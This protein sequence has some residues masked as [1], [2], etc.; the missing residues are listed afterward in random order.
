MLNTSRCNPDAPN[1][2][3][4]CDAQGNWGTSEPCATDTFCV[5]GDCKPCLPET[6]R[7]S[8]SG[9][10]LCSEAGEWVNQ[11]ACTGATPAC[12]EGT[13]VSCTPDDKRCGDNVVEVCLPDGSGWDVFET[14]SGDTPACL[15]STKTCGRC[16]LDE[17]QC[18]DDDV[19]TCDSEGVFQTTEMCS[20]ST[21]QCFDDECTE[22]DPDA[23]ERRCATAN[24]TQACN[25]DGSW[26]AA[27][28]CTGDTPECRE[29][30]GQVCG[31]EEDAR[32]C[33]ANSTTVPELCEGGTWVAQTACS[34]TLNHCLP[35]TGQCVDCAPGSAECRNGIAYQCNT[36]GSF[37]SLNSCAGPGIN[38]G[39]CGIGETCTQNSQCGT[40]ICVNG[41]CAV[42]QPNARDCVGTTPRLCSSEGT[43]TNQ[44]ACSGNTPVCLSSTGQCV[45]CSNGSS[46]NCGNC[47]TGTQSCSNNAWGTCSGAVDLNTSEE[48][49]GSCTTS[50]A[51]S[52]VCQSGMCGCAS[53]SHACGSGSTCYSN[54]D[55]THCGSSCLNCGSYVGTTG[56]CGS[57]LCTC[58]A[59]SALACG[60]NT[61][62]CGSWDFD[63]NTLEGWRFGDFGSPSDHHWVGSLGTMVTNGSPALHARYDGVQAGAGYIEFEVDLCPNG[64][65]VN[66]SNYVL[67]Y[68]FYFLTTGGSRFSQS[69]TDSNDSFLASNSS[70]F[71]ACQPFVEPGS[72]A[73]IRGTCS[74]LP[75]SVTNLTI[76]FRL[77]QGWA[78]SVFLDNVRFTPE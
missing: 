2:A 62:T 66:L 1:E 67:T 18:L 51:S 70:V 54:T 12:F 37:D 9:P 20:G 35:A 68:D 75:A 25:P 60:V 24:S 61:P 21:P 11:G 28:T 22:C 8:V 57:N 19:Q 14:C 7:C 38:C 10:Q 15:D 59:S 69:T 30:L 58:E 3:Q 53:G 16:A 43:W 5:A 42:C 65:I 64:A 27:E 33:R 32:R 48:Y 77:T 23:G 29:D 56:A 31:C 74:N 73:W 49:C 6:T 34:G 46:R 78:G 76:V 52:Q 71:L 13:C 39:N 63:S 50:C 55:G 4:S 72:D 36:D 41:K 26:A 45:A 47:N 17:K 44:T 40:G